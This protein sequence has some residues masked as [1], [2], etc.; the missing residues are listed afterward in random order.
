MAVA[1]VVI[2]AGVAYV[3]HAATTD[4]GPVACKI[5]E[6]LATLGVTEAQ[7]EQVHAILRAHQP[8]VEPMI[9]QLVA[10]R[11]ALRDTIRTTPVNESAIRAQAVKVATLEAD[12]AV[13][14]AYVVQ[15]VRGVL[16]PEQIEK[17][18]EMQVDVDARID[19]ALHRI[20]KRIA[21]D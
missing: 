5:A 13:Q 2:A 11:R 18:K 17:L 15:E 21:E 6:K 12:L 10:E 20:A 7:K 3:A 8:T 4:E 16:T 14:R 1:A 19:Q 9:H